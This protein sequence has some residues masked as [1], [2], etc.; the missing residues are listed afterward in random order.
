[1]LGNA[2]EWR[3]NRFRIQHQQMAPDVAPENR[4][5]DWQSITRFEHQDRFRG[6]S[7]STGLSFSQLW[8]W[9]ERTHILDGPFS[10]GA[11]PP[12]DNSSQ[13]TASTARS[14]QLRRSCELQ[15]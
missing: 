2:Q 3:V 14:I 15:V 1:M 9:L 8:S 5:S 7:G 10:W 6:C 13:D 4:M 12:L 11:A